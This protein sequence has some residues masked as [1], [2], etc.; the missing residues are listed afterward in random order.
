MID[1]SRHE[2]RHIVLLFWRMARWAVALVASITVL[3]ALYYFGVKKKEHWAW[4]VPGAIASALAW[5][6]ATLAFGF[7]VTRIANYSMFYGSFGAGIATLVWLYITAFS[8]LIGAELN[9]ALFRERQAQVSAS[10]ESDSA[11]SSL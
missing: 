9:G 8:V 5:F 2:L 4:V 11:S 10:R 3:S 1:N 6:L 7:Y